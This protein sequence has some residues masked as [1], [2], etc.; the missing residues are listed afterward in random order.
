MQIVCY[1]MV[2]LDLGEDGVME[3][4]APVDGERAP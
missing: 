4:S 3:P 1:F 2:S